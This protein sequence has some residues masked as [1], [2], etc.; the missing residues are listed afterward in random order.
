VR[1][2]MMF[3]FGAFI[4]ESSGH[5][6]EYLPYFRKRKDLLKKYCRDGY[7][8]GSSFYANCWPDWRKAS[9]KRRR[10]L[11]KDPSKFE[12][13]RGHEYASDIMEAHF[14]DRPRVIYGS[15]LNESL[16]PNLP[17]DG[18]VEVATLVDNTGYNP[19]RFGP[20]PPQM[21]AVCASHMPVYDLA[22]RAIMEKDREA[23][24]HAMLLDPLS[25]AVCSPAEI[26]EMTDQMALAESRFIPPFMTKGLKRT[27]SAGRKTAAR[28][29]TR[30]KDTSP[31]KV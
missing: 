16:I 14:F 10:E 23:F 6:S 5:L 30:T 12:L 29:R 31:F 20:L 25:A 8:G 11:A 9:D 28:K 27:R 18:V 15:V 2:E 17:A 3:H 13:K 7:R 4:T 24:Y 21:A 22:V 26:K 19:C 1:Y